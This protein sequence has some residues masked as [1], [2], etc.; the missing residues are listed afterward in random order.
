MAN[1]NDLPT[2]IHGALKSLKMY[3]VK[4]VRTQGAIEELTTWLHRRL[5]RH[6]ILHLSSTGGQLLLDGIPSGATPAALALRKEMALR[7]IGGIII[8]RGVAVREI[9][10]LL[11]TLDQRPEN[12]TELGGVS[13]VFESR[14][15]PHIQISLDGSP[16]PTPM[17]PM[18]RHIE[19][20]VIDELLEL[21]FAPSPTS[22]PPQPPVAFQPLE[23]DAGLETR[24]DFAIRTQLMELDK[25]QAQDLFREMLANGLLENLYQVMERIL[26]ALKSSTL[27]EM[28][29]GLILMDALMTQEQVPELP[30][31]VIQLLAEGLLNS[32]S[33]LGLEQLSAPATDAIASILTSLGTKG[34][35]APINAFLVRVNA[36]HFP[37]G[38][39]LRSRVLGSPTFVQLP[40]GV[41][42]QEGRSALPRLLPV[43][44]ISG[45]DGARTLT[46]LLGEETN[47]QHRNR[48]L[49]L[50]KGL[51][52]LGFPALRQCLT[53]GPWYLTR[54][55][56]N[57]LGD[58]GD[59][60][61]FPG[62]VHCLDHSDLRVRRAAL[63]A[64]WRLGGLKAEHILLD[65]L[66]R[67]D[68]ETQ[69]EIL[70][71]LGQI[72]AVNAIPAIGALASQAP[73]PLRIK[74][75]ETLGQI[76][77]GS[78]IPT[79]SEYLKRQGR[80]FKTAEPQGVR[81][82]AGNALGAIGIP[83]AIEALSR[84]VS[85]APK[86]G[87]Q[88]ALRKILEAHAWSMPG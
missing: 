10:E 9:Q 24:V 33:R 21:A 30:D 53:S 22:Q 16:A 42:F 85:E 26:M 40:L 73:E 77:H 64:L 14:R 41:L 6:P 67:S 18:A 3:S 74:A 65:H 31:G 23:Q 8:Q 56:L 57:L 28:Q 37:H 69:I 34:D 5:G 78:A 2:Q 58:M 1:T 87:D 45:E 43:F 48:I 55:A 84:A 80:I 72:R 25:N 86:N 4:H 19:P 83:E 66:Q 81:L 54:N 59:A 38:R 62:T 39:E 12:L 29:R 7:Q 60:K 15:C 20:M 46:R 88:A 27:G 61:A 75:L 47:R 49:E 11:E 35:L 82:A 76:G 32:L 71:G 70:F 52:E 50:L 63:R 79:L 68:S 36:D 17:A 44:K 13:R 51:G